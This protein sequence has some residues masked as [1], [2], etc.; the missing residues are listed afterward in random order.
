MSVE[1]KGKT[2][3]GRFKAVCHNIWIFINLIWIKRYTA[4]EAE[5]QLWR[6]DER[7]TDRHILYVHAPTHTH[8]HIREQLRAL[9]A[10]ALAVEEEG[11]RQ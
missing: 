4:G 3:S 11:E 1:W 8:T 7:K 5:W 2:Y 6:V 10:F 9:T